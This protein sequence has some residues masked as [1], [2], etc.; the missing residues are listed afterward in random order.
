MSFEEAKEL[1]KTITSKNYKKKIANISHV[2]F[3]PLNLEAIGECKGNGIFHALM[4]S[5]AKS[6][7]ISDEQL[8]VEIME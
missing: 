1:F 5:A 6:E 4:E 3:N 7:L 8:M 2:L